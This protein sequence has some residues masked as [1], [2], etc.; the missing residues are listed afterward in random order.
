MDDLELRAITD[1]E[2]DDW[3]RAIALGFSD[4]PNDKLAAA[5]RRVTEL[6]RTIAVFDGGEI[7]ANAGAFSFELTI[8][9]GSSLPA[10]GVTAVGVRHTHRRRGLLTRMMSHQL[11]DVAS[12]GEPLAVLTASETVIYGRYGY[13]MATQYSGWKV[14]TEGLVVEVPS[15]ARGRVRI[16][17][18]AEAAKVFPGIYDAARRRHPGAVAWSPTWWEFWFEDLEIDRDG[19]SARFYLVH[20][21]ADGEPDGLCAYNVKHKWERGLPMHNVAIQRLYGLDDEVEAA[22]FAHLVTIDLVGSVSGWGRPVDEPLRHRLANSRRMVVSHVGD[23]LWLRVLDVERAL[24]AREL[25]ADDR[26][27]IEVSDR[28]LPAAG[29]T[30]AVAPGECTRTDGGADLA[31]DARDLGAIYLGGITPTTLG[32]AGRIREL[33]PGALARAD[34]L[35]L[36]SQTPWCDT[37]F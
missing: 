4:H 3:H 15:T 22:L 10:A 23:H 37:E 18:R 35:F 28:F 8:P 24:S 13:G 36:S 27:V 6:D 26:I 9:G 5:W 16:V 21:N 29:G 7:V 33:T 1:D 31:M 25:A 32:R 34:R 20:E 19:A 14:D 11:A 30:F 2:Y 12:R 17:D